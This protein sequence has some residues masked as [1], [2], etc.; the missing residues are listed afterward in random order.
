MLLLKKMARV[1]FLLFLMP[2]ISL[3]QDFYQKFEALKNEL[4]YLDSSNQVIKSIS[5]SDNGN[6]IIIYGKNSFS[7]NQLPIN[8]E[9]YL[10]KISDSQTNIK[11]FDFL[12]DDNQ[13]LCLVKNNAYAGE[14]ISLSL[15]KML[16]KLNSSKREISKFFGNNQRWILLFNENEDIVTHGL[17]FDFVNQIKRISFK[18]QIKA[19][20]FYGQKGY[21]ILYQKN[22]FLAKNIPD[23]CQNALEELKKNDAEIN[24]VIF[25]NEA[26]IIIY[27]KNKFICNF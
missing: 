8:A 9:K 10:K 17:D 27:N 16:N 21:V 1:A 24:D 4:K 26:W 14:N 3:S 12:G 15:S 25:F 13:W 23:N 6:W 22:K 11:D 7:Y 20:S 2:L 18:K 19:I 5:I